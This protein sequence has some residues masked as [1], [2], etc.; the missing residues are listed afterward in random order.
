MG[1]KVCCLLCCF[2]E[3]VTDFV[4]NRP[5]EIYHVSVM[6]CY[7]KKL[8][9]S[10][11]DFHNEL[12]S[13]RDVDCV[14]TTGELELMMREKG[15]DLSV[16]VQDE[17]GSLPPGTASS[18]FPELM[19]HPGTSSGSYLHSLIDMYISTSLDLLD[20]SVRTVR[21]SDYEEYTLQ[22]QGSDEVV[23][24][25]AKCYGFRNL[26]NV[27]RKIGK[28]TGVQA[29][30]GAA[31]KMA[32]GLRA[33]MK[34]R[35]GGKEGDEEKEKVYDYVEVMACPGGCVN[36]GGQL[37]PPM[38]KQEDAEG[39][40]RNWEDSG[41]EMVPGKV[42]QNAKWGDKEWS[43]RVEKAYWHDLSTPPSSL[44]EDSV[45]KA[46]RFA[47]QILVDLCRPQER[48]V[49]VWDTLMDSAAESRR[50]TFFRTQYRVVESEVIGL[51]VKW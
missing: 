27:V 41:V 28:D 18:D 10:R 35:A 19:S 43:K 34:K 16:P 6:P 20:L 36:G 30:K 23:F 38:Q 45:R 14:I 12:Y 32:G 40:E 39:Y 15:W 1:E 48:E 22:K 7:D 9:A 47:A 3:E 31:G 37:K 42:T 49:S 5:D 33:R 4:L 21:T 8:E 25:G 26:Q 29:G 44:E 50:R 11:E 13:T 24:R 46:D 51:A 2:F 17:L